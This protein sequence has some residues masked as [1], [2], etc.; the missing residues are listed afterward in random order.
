[1][2]NKLRALSEMLE[3]L[4]NIGRILADALQRSTASPQ[5]GF[6][7]CAQGL[8]LF[9]SRDLPRA[10]DFPSVGR[11]KSPE[12]SLQSLGLSAPLNFLNGF[13]QRGWDIR[14]AAAGPKF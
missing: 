1:M 12:P 13:G 11:D 8:D 5:L 7:R 10:E 4:R 2:R 14:K 6:E 3:P 9:A